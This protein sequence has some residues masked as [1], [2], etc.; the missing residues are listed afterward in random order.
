MESDCPP[1]A[2]H[3][4]P[5][6]QAERVTSLLQQ[7]AAEYEAA[8]R[9]LA[10]ASCDYSRRALVEAHLRAVTA[11]QAELSQMLGEAL[12]LALVKARLEEVDR[13]LAAEEGDNAVAPGEEP[14]L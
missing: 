6:P 9:S 14:S 7:L 8:R 4:G 13:R 10:R 5:E 12:A 2:P 11:W 3:D 1:R